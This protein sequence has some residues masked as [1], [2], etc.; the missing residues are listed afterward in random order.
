MKSFSFESEEDEPGMLRTVS[1]VNQLI[2]AEIE[3]GIEPGRIVIGGFSQGG[4]ISVLTGLTN[5]Y[6]LAGVAC[7]SGWVL[8]RNKL[9]TVGKLHFS[10]ETHPETNQLDVF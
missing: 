7:L 4:A 5:D 8:L 1:C 6:K 10:L 9:K 2:S 3:S